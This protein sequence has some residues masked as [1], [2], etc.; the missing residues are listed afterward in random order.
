MSEGFEELHDAGRIQIS[1]SARDLKYE[2]G[3]VVTVNK[4]VDGKN[5]P[6]ATMIFSGIE[7]MKSYLTPEQIEILACA[8]HLVRCQ[9]VARNWDKEA[10]KAV[11]V[12]RAL[13]AK[14]LSDDQMEK[15]LAYIE[16]Q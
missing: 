12:T 5:V 8:N 11:Q 7:T 9:N 15:V 10:S 2:D 4:Q 13:K 16:K 6:H 14:G 3:D 1:V